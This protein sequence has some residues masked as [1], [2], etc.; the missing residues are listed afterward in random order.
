MWTVRCNNVKCSKKGEPWALLF[1]G[2]GKASKRAEDKG[3]SAIRKIWRN[4]TSKNE[5]TQTFPS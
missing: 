1:W 4:F 2:K 3:I 5:S